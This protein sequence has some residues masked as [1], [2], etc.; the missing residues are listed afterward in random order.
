[1]CSGVQDH[2]RSLN[3]GYRVSLR[4]KGVTYLNAYGILEDA[5][6]IKT[7]NKR[8][9][10]TTITTKYIILAPGGTLQLLAPPP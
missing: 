7:V 6:T 1:M 3:W 8:G 5:H 9:K 2:V 4:D 10:E